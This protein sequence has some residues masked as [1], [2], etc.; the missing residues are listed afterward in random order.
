MIRWAY[1]VYLLVFK[2]LRL[3]WRGRELL[4]LLSCN[5]VFMA[6]LTGAGAS[7]AML[8]RVTGNKIFPMLLWVVFIL[9]TLSSVS[10]SY[11]SELEGR[12]FE[13]LLLSGVTGSQMYLSKVLI[14]TALFFVNYVLLLGVLSVTLDQVVWSVWKE[15]V[16]VGLFSSSALASVVVILGAMAS[17]SRLRGVLTPLLALPLLFPLFFAGL[18]MTTELV[19]RGDLDPTSVWPSVLLAVNAV[20]LIVGLSLFDFVIRD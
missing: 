3:E 13:G 15:L 16:V 5:A 7:S 18:E 2:E 12:A 20:F 19:L 8:D 10:R 17:T 9:S 14:S 6:V 4:T 1:I 11:E